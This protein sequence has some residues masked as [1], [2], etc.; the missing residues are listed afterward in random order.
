MA[1]TTL[2]GNNFEEVVVN[3]DIPV[4]VDFYADWCK[5]C[6]RI[7]PTLEEIASEKDGEVLV[8]KVDV[9]QSQ[10]LAVAH[11][12]MSIPNIISFKGG[13][14]YRRVVGA[15]SKEELLALVE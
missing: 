6:K 15:V 4:I 5:P 9:D 8:C 13:E 7:A 11:Q 2:T 3:S 14:V 12:V 1:V 10:E